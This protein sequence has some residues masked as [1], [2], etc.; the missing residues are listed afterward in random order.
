MI[1]F[2]SAQASNAWTRRRISSRTWRN[3]GKTSSSLP[4]A[5]AGSG[6]AQW[7]RFILT[8][9][10]GQRSSASPQRVIT[11][12][13][14]LSGTLSRPLEDCMEMSMPASC[15]TRTASGWMLFGSVPA[16][17]IRYLP[18]ADC[19]AKP[20]AIWLRHELPVHRNKIAWGAGSSRA[21]GRRTRT[22]VPWFT[23]L[24][25]L[26][27]PLWAWTICLTMARPS[28]VPPRSRE[29]ALSTR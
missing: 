29:R 16:L 3:K 22:V 5:A 1:G 15:I 2:V 20:S 23:T 12:S 28:P 18:L 11:W 27:S 14:S 10:V 9:K 25:I 7:A 26:S 17:K 24:S 8:P 6:S 19:R 4:A 21:I 13:I